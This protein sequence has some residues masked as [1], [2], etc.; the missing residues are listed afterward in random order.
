MSVRI[1]LLAAALVAPAIASH[2]AE[3][4]DGPWSMDR[5]QW[6]QAHPDETKARLREC[7]IK[8]NSD[9]E[10]GAALQACGDLVKQDPQAAC[11]S[12]MKD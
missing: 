8:S 11:Q 2:A 6:Y 5:V 10:C 1:L 7:V 12:P 4:S 3:Q 9:D